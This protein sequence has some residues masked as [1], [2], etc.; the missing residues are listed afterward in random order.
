MMPRGPPRRSLCRSYSRL[1]K[2]GE[3]TYGTVYRATCTV[4]GGPTTTVAVKDVK[5]VKDGVFDIATSLSTL[6]EIKLLKEL[7][8]A[9][10]VKLLDVALDPHKHIL[11]LVFEYRAVPLRPAPPHTAIDMPRPVACAVRFDLRFIIRH[12]LPK[13]PGQMYAVKCIMYHIL[14]GLHYLHSNWVIHRDLKPQNILVAEDG[15]SAGVVKLAGAARLRTLRRPFAA[16]HARAPPA[17]AAML[18][19]DFGLAR[20][21]QSPARPL[22]EVERVVVTL[23]YRAP[24]LLLGAQ[25]YTRAVD[26]WA[27]GCVFAEVPC[28]PTGVLPKA[29]R[30]AHVSCCATRCGQLLQ[31]KELFNGAEDMSRGAPFQ[32]QQCECIFRVLGFPSPDRWPDVVHLAHWPR[33]AGWAGVRVYPDSSMLQQ[34]CVRVA[35]RVAP[36]ASP[37]PA[38]VLGLQPGS[39]ALDLIS[40][41]LEYGA[42]RTHML[43][44]LRVCAYR[45]CAAVM[46]NRATD[47]TR[48]ISAQ[49][50]MSHAFFAA[51]SACCSILAC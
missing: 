18:R 33:V 16:P 3:G 22:A 7:E 34:V 37:T 30:A 50:A 1:E 44:A 28:P 27:A 12:V 29:K 11:S 19:S 20:I 6:R 45:A 14:S 42:A 2:V 10:V 47:P 35:L 51:V 8:H 48:R 40:R 49:E 4:E 36:A 38:Q 41:M 9:H 46:A 13:M 23:W 15:P 39:A 25:H 24:E 5:P 43:R 32:A 26:I 21:F 17:A 31:G